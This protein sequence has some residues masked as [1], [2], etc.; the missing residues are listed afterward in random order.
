ML[1]IKQIHFSQILFNHFHIIPSVFIQTSVQTLFTNSNFFQNIQSN[2]Y[3]QPN[4]TILS[5]ILSHISMEKE[6]QLSISN[7]T[8]ASKNTSAFAV[9][10]TSFLFVLQTKLS[11][12]KPYS[13]SKTQNSSALVQT[14]AAN[15]SPS[16]NSIFSLHLQQKTILHY[17]AEIYQ[18]K[19]TI[20]S[21]HTKFH[22]KMNS[23]TQHS[24][25]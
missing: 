16:G 15:Y 5:V 3:S 14:I 24:C 9:P 2:A 12:T 18:K 22:L 4:S 19:S 25:S 1:S 13:N 21:L 11:L 6:P 10:N 20:D 23:Q 7:A 8:A 17:F